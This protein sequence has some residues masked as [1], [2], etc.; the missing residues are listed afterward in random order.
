MLLLGKEFLSTAK[1]K[2]R[3][4]LESRST[5]NSKEIGSVCLVVPAITFSEVCSDRN[6]SPIELVGQVG[7]SPRETFG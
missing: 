7:L 5:A 3:D 2:Q 6:R 1:L 4:A